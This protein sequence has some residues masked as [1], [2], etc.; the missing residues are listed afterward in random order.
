MLVHVAS[1]SIHS[2][3]VQLRAMLPTTVHKD[4]KA[5]HLK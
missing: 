5:A 2:F 4:E 1:S 3:T